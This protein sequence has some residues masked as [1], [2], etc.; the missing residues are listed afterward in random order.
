MIGN[1]LLMQLRIVLDARQ[2]SQAARSFKEHLAGGLQSVR[3]NIIRTRDTFAALSRELNGF[4]AISRTAFALG[5]V[6]GAREALKRNRD[7]HRDLLEMKQTAELSK[8]TS[9]EIKADILASAKNLNAT[10]GELL[11]AVRQYT[12]AGYS[13]EKFAL[14]R[15]GYKESARAASA[16]FT[17]PDSVAKMDVDLMQKSGIRP[18]SLP[19]VHNMLLYHGRAGR[20]EA[21]DF[22]EN[23]PKIL[24]A[25]AL[26]GLT[27]ERGV[28]MTLGLAQQFMK[29][30]PANQKAE[31]ATFFEH[32]FGHITDKHYVASLAKKGVDV[33]SHFEEREITDAEGNRSKRFVFKGEGG[34]EGFMGLLDDLNR[35]GVTN[36][37][38]ASEMGF[39]E[40]YTRKAAIQAVLGKDDL[41]A[42]M[43]R[44]EQAARE[45][46]IGV[47][48]AEIKEADFGKI[49]AA[50]IEVEKLTLSAPV[51]TTSNVV[52]SMVAS[53]AADLGGTALA[54]GGGGLLARYG[55]KR[56][57]FFGGIGAGAG[58]AAG[59]AAA[60]GGSAVG[61]SAGAAATV[62]SGAMY[63]MGGGFGG[64]AQA[65]A[66]W[67]GTASRWLGRAAPVLAVGAGAVNYQ[68]IEGDRSLGDKERTVAHGANAGGTL[69]GLAGGLAGA[70]VGAL[71]GS[72]VAPGVGTVIG[73]LLGGVVGGFGG[74]K[75]G[76]MFGGAVG[77]RVAAGREEQLAAAQ[78]A[79][80][81]LREVR[82]GV[83]G[84]ADRPVSVTLDGN[85]VA[86]T[87]NESNGRLAQRN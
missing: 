62:G 14:A 58:S 17:T 7:F 15:T 40:M 13:G 9:E 63:G 54:L 75:I 42:S 12:A 36:Q 5:G 80:S 3:Q 86:A 19:A 26:Q 55:L 47:A 73:A 4:S 20:F 16:M 61:G 67:A 59:G 76:E 64:P 53:G 68:M 28:N 25:A 78:E 49:K 87:V 50:E 65:T 21:Q 27:G 6:A 2:A 29:L 70:K 84:L 35:H 79:N 24:N 10:P 85:Q 83:K 72:A 56:L 43:S 8:K 77:E 81:L 60:V 41:L 66:A 52:S 46:L 38:I 11:S 34:V 74:G 69:G 31:V 45:D 37:F 39:R 33:K 18:E 71:L 48:L 44:G 30:A 22:S 57:G 23:A 1:E 51:T 32:F 82:D